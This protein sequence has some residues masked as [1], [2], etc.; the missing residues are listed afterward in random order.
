MEDF[1]MTARKQ[2]LAQVAADRRH[3]E[4]RIQWLTQENPCWGDGSPVSAS[5]VR[6]L[7][8]QSRECLAD[9]SGMTGFNSA[10]VE[11]IPENAD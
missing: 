3:H 10:S 1:N 4:D 6:Q 7:L 5:D 9:R 11:E 8:R 2:F